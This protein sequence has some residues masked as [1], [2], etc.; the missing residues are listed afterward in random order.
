[1]RSTCTTIPSWTTAVTVPNR[2]P[3]SAVW[4]R[5]RASWVRS[6]DVGPSVCCV[7]FLMSSSSNRIV[8]DED[9]HLARRD[10]DGVAGIQLELVEAFPAEID[11]QHDAERFRVDAHLHDRAGRVDVCDLRFK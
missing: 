3:R 6:M 4:M 7:S 9:A 8:L 1:V 11:V 2:S 10:V 5:S